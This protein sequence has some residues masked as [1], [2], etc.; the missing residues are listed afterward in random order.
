MRVGSTLSGI[1]LIAQHSLLQAYNQVDLSSVRL[2]T[3][4]RINSGSKDPAGLIAVENLRAELTAINEATD[5]AARAGAVVRTADSALCQVSSLLNTVEGNVVAALSGGRSDAELA[6]LQMEIDA[7]LEAVNRIGDSTSFGGKKLLEGGEMTFVLSPD[8]S[9]VSTL[10]LPAISTSTLGGPAGL[11][12]NLGSGGSASLA[13]GD[14]AAAVEVLDAASSQVLG[15][16]ARLGAFENCAIKPA[17]RV[18]ESMEENLSA[19]FSQIFDTDTAEESARLVRSQI[20]VKAS[21][22]SVLLAGQSRSQIGNL[23]GGL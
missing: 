3:M 5:N 12:S 8:A 18:L 15:A 2:S 13:D 7:A 6:A 19:A 14:L 9:D 11:L 10:S 23:L 22:S 21:I 4:R 1:D 20:L 17:V 16:Q